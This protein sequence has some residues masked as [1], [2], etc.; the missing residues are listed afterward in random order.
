MN[1]YKCYYCWRVYDH[2]QLTD[3]P[4]DSC[5]CGSRKFIESNNLLF[6]R[7]LTDFKYTFVAWIRE[8]L[9]HEKAS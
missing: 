3:G 4:Y 5:P 6:R 7:F 1:Y 9:N 2:W 8:R